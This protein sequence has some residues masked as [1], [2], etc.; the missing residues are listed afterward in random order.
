MQTAAI[1]HAD[2]TQIAAWYAANKTAW[3]QHMLATITSADCNRN[4]EQTYVDCRCSGC[5]GLDDQD[6]QQQKT[7]AALTLV[8]D[9]ENPDWLSDL[10]DIIDDLYEAPSLNDDF[11]DLEIDL[12]EEL[13]LK[14]FPET[15]K[16]QC[17][18]YPRFREYQTEAPRRAVYRGRC[19]K[20][21]GYMDNIREAEDDNVSH[22]LSCGW[23]TS[24]AYERNRAFHAAGGE[25]K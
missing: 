18:E 1:L 15:E 7:P 20:C 2:E 11:D 5:G 13:M 8:W 3:C 21:R 9:A 25:I 4:R 17:P 22:C 19:K 10:D 6:K 12:E 24:P 14:L 16:E 23:R